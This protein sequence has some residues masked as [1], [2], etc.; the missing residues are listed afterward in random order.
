MRFYQTY[1]YKIF[2]IFSTIYFVEIKSD[3]I[4]N[5]KNICGKVLLIEKGG[6]DSISRFFYKIA[7][8]YSN[9]FNSQFINE[10]NKLH[11]HIKIK[12][13]NK[14]YVFEKLHVQEVTDKNTINKLTKLMVFE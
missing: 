9:I 4:I 6:F 8:T 13:L 2:D 12:S 5:D 11:E 7:K 14:T 1:N 10:H 3:N